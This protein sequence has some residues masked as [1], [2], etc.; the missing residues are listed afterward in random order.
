MRIAGESGV[1]DGSDWARSYHR[2]QGAEHF[3]ANPQKERSS[4]FVLGEKR[5]SP[6]SRMAERFRGRLCMLKENC[7]SQASMQRQM[8][9]LHKHS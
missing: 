4:A 2:K 5:P 3:T 1:A 8:K 6:A 7:W 9:K